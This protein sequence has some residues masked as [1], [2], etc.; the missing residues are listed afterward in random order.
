MMGS[1]LTFSNRII[2]LFSGGLAQSMLLLTLGCKTRAVS[3]SKLSGR[4]GN[5]RP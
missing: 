2:S 5:G 1:G 4:K 3:F